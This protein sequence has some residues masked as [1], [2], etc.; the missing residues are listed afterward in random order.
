MP[1]PDTHS[2]RRTRRQDPAAF[3]HRVG[4]TARMGRSGAGLALLLPSEATYADFL[5]LRR[6]P[7]A[8]GQPLP[9]DEQC[10]LFEFAC[11]TLQCTPRLMPLRCSAHPAARECT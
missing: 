4:R 10:S 2:R 6:V 9:G 8:Q 1:T 3:V 11:N 7:L 5:K